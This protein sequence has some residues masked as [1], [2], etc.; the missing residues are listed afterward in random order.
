MSVKEL[1]SNSSKINNG[2][3]SFAQIREKNEAKRI[4]NINEKELRQ[5]REN[6]NVE[7][8]TKDERGKSEVSPQALAVVA[9]T[10][11]FIVGSAMHSIIYNNLVGACIALGLGI[12][13]W[14]ILVFE[15]R[16]KRTKK[17]E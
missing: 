13:D 2:R 6:K 4:E 10:I 14:G 16:F 7:I 8:S 15:D 17:K 3:K 9:A 1:K 11:P 12:L 5:I